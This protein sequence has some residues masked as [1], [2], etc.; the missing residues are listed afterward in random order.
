MILRT[1]SVLVVMTAIGGPVAAQVKC[2]E[3]LPPVDRDAPSR[4]TVQE[5]IREVTATE[6]AAS[7]A[8]ADFGYT[9]D[10]TVQTLSGDAVDGEYRHVSTVSVDGAATRRDV[11]TSVNTLKRVKFTDRDL[12]TL[13]DAFTLTPE[14]IAGGDVVYSGRQHLGE[15]NA[16]LFNVLPRNPDAE[17]RGF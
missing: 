3:G 11:A 2:A 5:F 1:F 15:I 14:R 7:R 6:G 17:V 9:I 16:S 8:L 12:E 4:M 10:A 13:R